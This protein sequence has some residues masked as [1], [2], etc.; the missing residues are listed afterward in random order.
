MCAALRHVNVRNAQ[1]ILR[2]PSAK[3]RIR[4]RD[5]EH[6]LQGMEECEYVTGERSFEA[7]ASNENRTGVRGRRIDFLTGRGRVRSGRS[8]PGSA[9]DAEPCIGSSSHAR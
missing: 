6:R 7:Q 9:T 2:G 3:R 1:P 4:E 5:S 8:E